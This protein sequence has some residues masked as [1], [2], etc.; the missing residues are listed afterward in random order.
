M[1][2]PSEQPGQILVEFD[3]IHEEMAELGVELTSDGMRLTRLPGDTD[4][5]WARFVDAMTLWWDGYWDGALAMRRTISS[6][7]A[8]Q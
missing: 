5:M 4:A 6:D 7:A 1:Q 2:E 8:G 3:A